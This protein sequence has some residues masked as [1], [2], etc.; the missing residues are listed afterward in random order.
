MYTYK[1]HEHVANFKSNPKFTGSVATIP[2]LIMS[3]LC[4][5]QRIIFWYTLSALVTNI[6]GWTEFTT[7]FFIWSA[8]GQIVLKI[9]TL[10]IYSSVT[11]R[12]LV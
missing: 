8:V 9:P 1:N 7:S 12:T 4:H 10:W 6:A 11:K 2:V 3:V 5:V